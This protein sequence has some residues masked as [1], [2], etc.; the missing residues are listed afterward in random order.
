MIFVRHRRPKGEAGRSKGKQEETRRGA[1]GRGKDGKEK[2]KASE[3]E[4]GC[5]S[6]KRRD[7]NE[8]PVETEWVDNV[9]IVRREGTK[10]ESSEGED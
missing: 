8:H 2:C 7:K 4:G 1:K 3:K 5:R 10:R 9:L 6:K